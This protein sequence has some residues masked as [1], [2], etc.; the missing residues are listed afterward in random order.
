VEHTIEALNQD[1]S[2]TRKTVKDAVASLTIGS[3]SCAVLLTHESISTT[4]NH[5]RS[6]AIHANTR[7]HQL[8]Q[9]HEDPTGLDSRPLM[10]TDSE[11][12]MQEGIETGVSTMQQLLHIGQLSITD[13]ERT[14]CH[15]VGSAHRKLMLESLGLNPEQ[16]FATYSWLGN[17]GSAAAPISL[18]IG[19][20]QQFIRPGQRVGVL[21][22]GSGINCLMLE[23]LWQNSQ[24]LGSTWP[25]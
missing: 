3:A 16:D 2:L 25:G 23:L 11:N 8:C 18:A 4:G 6:V 14:V 20:E 7:H 24:I 21:G 12:L 10:K 5:L 17:T 19:A 1:L 22:I 9:S 15:Q 13:F